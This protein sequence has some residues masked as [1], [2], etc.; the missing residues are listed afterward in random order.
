[1]LPWS[2]C[3]NT[4]VSVMEMLKNFQS[5]TSCL[6]GETIQGIWRL[7]KTKPNQTKPNQTMR[8]FNQI[9]DLKRTC[10]VLCLFLWAKS[11]NC[12]LVYSGGGGGSLV[13]LVTSQVEAREEESCGTVSWQSPS[14]AHLLCRPNLAGFLRSGKVGFVLI[15][16]LYLSV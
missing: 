14:A 4:K 10:V 2:I 15:Q 3:N 11:C 8:N 7:F 9:S 13:A 5:R 12:I 1:M 16:Q 6:H